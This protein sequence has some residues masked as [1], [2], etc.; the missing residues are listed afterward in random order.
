MTLIELTK[1]YWSTALLVLALI[2]VLVLVS[3]FV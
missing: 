3:V 1:R 2:A